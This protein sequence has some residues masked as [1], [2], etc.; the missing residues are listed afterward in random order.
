MI[1]YP[2]ELRTVTIDG[3]AL[4]ITTLDSPVPDLA[5]QSLEQA[6]WVRG[7]AQDRALTL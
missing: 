1:E 6:E 5:A 2:M 7:R 4:H 3:D